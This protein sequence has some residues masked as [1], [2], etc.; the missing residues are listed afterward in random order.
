MAAI[1]PKITYS[2]LTIIARFMVMAYQSDGYLL[3][4]MYLIALFSFQR[5]I[6]AFRYKSIII[7]LTSNRILSKAFG[8]EDKMYT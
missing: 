7:A 5:T 4:R 1:L 3:I 2:A 6:K 8:K